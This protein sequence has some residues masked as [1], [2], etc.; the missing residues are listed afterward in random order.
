MRG[1][2][3][4]GQN[5]EESEKEKERAAAAALTSSCCCC[6]RYVIDVLATANSCQLGKEGCWIKRERKSPDETHT[7]EYIDRFCMLDVSK[8]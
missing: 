3:R 7:Y 8:I 2:A 5:S 6:L 4:A 1:R